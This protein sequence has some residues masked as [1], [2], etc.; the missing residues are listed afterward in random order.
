[1]R[2]FDPP[3]ESAIF[4]Q[5]RVL[6]PVLR[7]V[8][9]STTSSEKY[10]RAAGCCLFVAASKLSAVPLAFLAR[11][12]SKSLKNCHF[13]SFSGCGEADVQ[14]IG[15]PRVSFHSWHVEGPWARIWLR[16]VP[17]L[18]RES[19][20]CSLKKVAPLVPVRIYSHILSF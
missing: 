13:L 18:A 11:N 9:A 4:Q 16:E 12:I 14:G 10:Q 1:M 17:L 3:A 15:N 2:R 19:T 8:R 5:S 7:W 6:N 20:K